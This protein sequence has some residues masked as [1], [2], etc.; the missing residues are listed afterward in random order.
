[1]K[2]QIYKLHSII[3][4]ALL[5]TQNVLVVNISAQ[6]A[7]TVAQEHFDKFN[8]VN[9]GWLASDAT[10]SLLLPDG[11]TLWLFG[12]C[13]IGEKNGE[14]GINPL[15]SRMINNAAVL[16]EGNTLTA[17]YGGNFDNPTSF[18]P[19]DGQDIF[20]PEHAILEN[21]TLKV[22]AVR[23]ILQDVGVPGFNFRIGTSHIASYRYP[24]LEYIKTEKIEQI[25]DTTMRFGACIVKSGDYTYIF[26]KKDT[27]S[28]GL[29]WP[30]PYLA[31]VKESIDEPWQFFSGPESWSYDCRDAKPVGDR[32]M[33]ESFFVYEKNSKFYLIMHEIWTVGELFILEADKITGPWNRSTSGGK[34]IR[35]AV[36]QPHTNNFTYNLFAHPQ[37][38]Q[39]EK[40]LVSV[41]VNTSNFSSIYTDTRN[42]RARFYWLSVEEAVEA[43]I[44]D[45]IVLFES[46][47]PVMIN[48]H[49]NSDSRLNFD[50]IS[51]ELHLKEI[52][53]PSLLSIIGTDGKIYMNRRV[54]QD[55]TINC[56]NLPGTL[57]IIQLLNDQGIE[58]TRV[59]NP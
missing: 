44:P 36:I 7:I 58:T 38:R 23:I 42:Y 41:N 1:M 34:E 52:T 14:F 5:L 51:H 24:G 39:D 15:K 32:P 47:D 46:T 29:T 25:T 11:N 10:I 45:T 28:G 17:Y 55:A 43:V 33:S 19:G 31:R 48:E 18:I 13:F 16:E 35:F 21:D 22:F 59:F 6:Q 4:F 56:S 8:N 30:V 40:I 27:T 49:K 9:G 50:P 12:D 2:A 37:F 26:G 53:S 20:W 57:L 54:S 3:I